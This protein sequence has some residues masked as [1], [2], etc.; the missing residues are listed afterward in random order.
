MLIIEREPEHCVIMANNKGWVALDI[1]MTDELKT[2][3]VMRDLLR[4]LQV[5]RRD[6]R[7]EIE[8]RI[9][10]RYNTDSEILSVVISQY[11]DYLC[12]QL[13]CDMFERWD[14]GLEDEL[15]IGPEKITVK[16]LKS[17]G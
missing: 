1:T 2:E 4:R 5:L 14:S 15:T 11:N 7:F 10:I 3:G 17:V 13:L 8:D 16:A 12:E 9:I 6:R